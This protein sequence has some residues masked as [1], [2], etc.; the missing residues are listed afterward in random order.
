MIETC[1]SGLR[2][3]I[4]WSFSKL[5]VCIE[6]ELDYGIQ[7]QINLAL[8]FRYYLGLPLGWATNKDSIAYT[9]YCTE[10]IQRQF[11][12]G[13]NYDVKSSRW[14]HTSGSQD[15]AAN[16]RGANAAL[17]DPASNL[18]SFTT[19]VPRPEDWLNSDEE[20]VEDIV[21]VSEIVSWFVG[22]F[23]PAKNFLKFVGFALS[24]SSSW[25]MLSPSVSG[26]VANLQQEY[27]GFSFKQLDQSYFGIQGV[28]L[29][30][31]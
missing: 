15:E 18:S 2:E 24:L 8:P 25:A 13:K 3:M 27:P 19:A 21:F 16:W 9:I 26:S 29:L 6:Q 5:A 23:S 10:W 20:T 1:S 17:Y 30:Q 14:G 4:T 22:L 7:C 11:W 12:E 31:S 28:E